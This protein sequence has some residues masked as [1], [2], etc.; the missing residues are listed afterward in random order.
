[1]DS[2]IATD[3]LSIPPAELKR[4]GPREHPTELGVG[5]TAAVVLIDQYRMGEMA[6]SVETIVPH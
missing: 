4:N 1:M 5:A 3:A 2:I 6:H